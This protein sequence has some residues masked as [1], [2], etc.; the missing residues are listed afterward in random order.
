MAMEI[1]FSV[2]SQAFDETERRNQLIVPWSPWF[3]LQS[4]FHIL[5]RVVL[6]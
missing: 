1:I 2:G 3:V 5:P 6:S 4:E